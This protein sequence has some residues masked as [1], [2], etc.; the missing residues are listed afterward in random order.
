MYHS[1]LIHLP[2]DGQ[3]GWDDLREQHWN[4]YITICEIDHQSK[5]DAWNRILKASALEH[6][7][8]W[9]GEGGGR[10]FQDGGH[11][12]THGWFMPVYGENHRNI[13]K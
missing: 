12:Y 3:L 2:A 13:V 9:D 6:S 10:G 1:F 5:F 8:G 11:M 4:M 7:E